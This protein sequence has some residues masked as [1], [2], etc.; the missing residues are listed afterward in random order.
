MEKCRTV[1]QLMRLLLREGGN[2]AHGPCDT[3]LHA[4]IGGRRH[5]KTDRPHPETIHFSSSP[6]S[7]VSTVPY[8]ERENGNNAC[9]NGSSG[10]RHVEGLETDRRQ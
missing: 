2:L 9:N 5:A 7:E 3:F 6:F 10:I 1:A 8:L 4:S